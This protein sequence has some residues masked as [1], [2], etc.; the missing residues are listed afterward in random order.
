MRWC[1]LRM[2]C[3]HEVNEATPEWSERRA[4]GQVAYPLYTAFA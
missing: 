3:F 4:E 2:L 1:G